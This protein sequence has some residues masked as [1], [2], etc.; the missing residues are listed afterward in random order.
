MDPQKTGLAATG[1]LI[2][3]VF[4]LLVWKFPGDDTLYPGL[5]ES[6]DVSPDGL[7]YTFRLRKDVTF[8]NGEPFNADSVKY[9]FDRLA[10]PGE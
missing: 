1:R 2:S 3:N 6:W 5:A 4:D 8:H 9:T 10:D 7:E